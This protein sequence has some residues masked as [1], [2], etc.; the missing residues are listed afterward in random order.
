MAVGVV[1]V[2]GWRCEVIDE[3]K[4]TFGLL[5]NN[6]HSWPSWRD[7]HWAL[8]T[9]RDVASISSSPLTRPAAGVSD[10]DC[11]ARGLAL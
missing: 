1:R 6:G 3:S 11:S 5:L 2:D 8:V 4:H 9:C 7:G 10:C